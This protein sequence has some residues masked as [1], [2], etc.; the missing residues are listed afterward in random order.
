MPLQTPGRLLSF[1]ASAAHDLGEVRARRITVACR[2]LFEDASTVLSDGT[3]FLATG[4]IPAMWLRDSTWQVRPLLSMNPDDEVLAYLGAVSQRQARYVL[5]DPYANAFNPAPDGACWHRD[6]VDQDPWVFE[7]K[8]EVD[9]LA[10][11]LD[12]ALRISRETAYRAHLDGVFWRAAERVVGVCE[13]EIRHDPATYRFLRPGATS[14]DT[15]GN[16]GYGSD[17]TPNGMVWSGFRPSDDRC[18]LPYLVP[19]NAHLAVVLEWLADDTDC[20]DDLAHRAA[21]LALGIRTALASLSDASRVL[22]YEVDG[23]G[24]AVFMDE[25]N[26]P[27]LLALPY[28]GW[29]APDD[30]VY[31]ATRSWVLSDENPY[32]VDAGGYQGLSSEHTP[33]GWIWPLSIAMRGLTTNDDRERTECLESLERSTELAQHESFD[34]LDPTRFTRPWF[35]WADMTYVQLALS[36]GTDD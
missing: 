14:H 19:A 23:R 11:F 32:F 21:S 5:I 1:L 3:V 20:P 22:P 28:L 4:D 34:P 15:L 36:L 30:P 24:G 6:F 33:P 29:C 35:S 8:F 2:R 17:C 18:A 12:L 16:D 25:P 13:A 7:R 26:I 27:N 31:R 9:S 10:A